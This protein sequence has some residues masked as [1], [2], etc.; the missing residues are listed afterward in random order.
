MNTSTPM[1]TIADTAFSIAA[2]RAQESERPAAERLFE[3]PYASVFA[4]AGTH[5]SEGT[6]RF[7]E[8]PFFL[9]AIRLRTRCIDDFV[10]DGLAAGLDQIVLLGAGFD[11][12]GLRMPEIAARG[13]SVYEVD[14]AAQLD[15]KREI[16]AAA[17]VPLPAHV[18]HIACDFKAP[19]FEDALAAAL[20]ERGFRRGAGAIFPWEGVIAYLDRAAINRSL[21]FMTR[22][23]GRGSRLVFDF[24]SVLFEPETAQE[25]TQRGGFTAFEEIGYDDLWRRY[26]PGEPHP[27]ASVCRM[28]MAS[29]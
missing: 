8:L 7:R 17:G 22:I 24:A 23:G 3:D 11:S 13:A 25:L 26:L 19:D 10:R 14:F 21:G 28:G 29:V 2:L 4:A 6:K 12:R 5:A 1:L 27:N 15:A 9:D 20:E 16:L 18:A